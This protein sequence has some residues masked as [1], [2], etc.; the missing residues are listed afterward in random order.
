[1]MRRSFVASTLAVAAGSIGGCRRPPLAPPAGSDAP[2]IHA[3]SSEVDGNRLLP[4]AATY[5]RTGRWGAARKDLG[6]GSVQLDAAPDRYA[7]RIEMESKGQAVVDEM[8]LDAATLAPIE[9]RFPMGDRSVFLRY[10][11]R[12]VEQS[13]TQHGR[14]DT[15]TVDFAAA[16]FEANAL[17]LVIA[18]LPLREG[19]TAQLAWANLPAPDQIWAR[20]T[21]LGRRDITAAGR[22]FSTHLCEAHFGDRSRRVMWLADEAPYK[23]RSETY[24]AGTSKYWD[25]QLDRVE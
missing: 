16:G 21:V 8:M 14:V 11:G 10:D 20:V 15:M 5:S 19:F 2:K 9:R 18:A 23:V 12:H 4:F 3:G 24:P 25:W 7:L 22:D 6:P 17:E 13:I 1:M